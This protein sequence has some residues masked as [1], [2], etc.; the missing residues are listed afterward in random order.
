MII[1]KFNFLSNH[2]VNDPVLYP[3]WSRAYEYP[4]VLENLKNDSKSNLKI[5]NTSWGFKNVHV[6]FRDILDDIGE[7]T[8]SD[9]VKSEYRDTFYYDITKEKNDFENKFDY[10]I[11]VSTIEHLPSKK[12]QLT[13]L[14]N[15]YK[16]V[17]KGGK[18][19]V[20]FD[21]PRVDLKM[22]EEWVNTKCNKPQ[23]ILNGS[24][25][26]APDPRYKNLNVIFLVIKKQ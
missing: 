17:K 24:N 21:Y 16:Q 7:C 15:L 26:V 1:E 19:I 13:A 18:L 22:I 11:N 12:L 20:T 14:K 4:I 25:S 2:D 8:H 3:N 23:S 9:I 10:V 5:H 6:T